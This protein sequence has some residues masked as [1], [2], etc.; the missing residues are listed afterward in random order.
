MLTQ[1]TDN[2]W[3]S[4]CGQDGQEENTRTISE[5]EILRVIRERQNHPYMERRRRV[6]ETVHTSGDNIHI[7]RCT[8][9]RDLGKKNLG[10]WIELEG[11]K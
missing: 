3:L 4:Y 10:L 6:G 8:L 11:E 9:M 1:L 5:D 2:T 7:D